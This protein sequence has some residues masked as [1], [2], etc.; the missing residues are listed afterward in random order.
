MKKDLLRFRNSWAI[1]FQ[2]LFDYLNL[3]HIRPPLFFPNILHESV[4]EIKI[5]SLELLNRKWKH[6][7][8]FKFWNNS[9][10]LHDVVY[11]F[12]SI[13][14]CLFL[15]SFTRHIRY[16]QTAFQCIT[17]P[18]SSYTMLERKNAYAMSTVMLKGSGG[19][20]PHNWPYP[21]GGQC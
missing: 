18:V 19:V 14:L 16:L 8:E 11:Y 6:T 15:N 2:H 7:Q 3:D 9:W 1:S 10:N 20:S 12:W 13:Y 5:D 17:N 21:E 4:Q